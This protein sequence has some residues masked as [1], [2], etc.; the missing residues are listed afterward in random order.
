MAAGLSRLF[1]PIRL[2]HLTAK[3]RIVSTPH[4]TGYGV[5]GRLTER[6]IRYHEEKARG[7]CGVVMMFGSS[8]VHPSSAVDWGEVNNLDDSIVPDFRRMSEA[9]HRHDAIV[10]SQI[11]HRGRRGTSAYSGYPLWAPSDVRAETHR[12][13][14]H[15]MTREEIAEVVAAYAMAARRL[16]EGGFDGADVPL[17]GGHLPEQF[18]SPLSNRRDDEYGGSLENRLRFSVEIFRAI[19]ATVGRDF[20]LG[21]R[22]SGDHFIEGGLGVA[23]MQ[24]VAAYLDGLGL[25]DYAIVSGSVPETI[26]LQA[27]VTPSLYYPRGVYNHLAAAIREVVSL[28]VIVAGRVVTPQMAEEVLA[29]GWAD[30]V[31]MTRA[32]I[33]DPEMPQK[34]QEGRLDDIRICVGAN[35]GCIG[36][37]RQGKPISCVQ[38]PTI[39]REAELSAIVPAAASKRVVVVGGGPAGLEAARVAALRGHHVV[40]FEQEEHLGG[41]I[42]ALAQAPK[43]EEYAGIVTW[44]T[45]QVGKLGVDVRLGTTATIDAVRAERPDAIVVATGAAPRR[46]NL[47][48]ANGPNVVTAY[49]VLLGRSAVGDRCIIIDEEG[50]FEAPTTADF[51]A[52]CGKQVQIVCRFYNVG[53]DIDENV[54]A[55]VYG[56]LFKHGITLTPLTVAQEIRP[57]QVQTRHVYSG[58]LA[59]LEADTVVLAFGGQARDDL[60]YQLR[61]SAAQ[62]YLVGDAV[63]PRRIHDAILD[64]TRTARAI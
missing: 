27:A 19:R 42:I 24:A 5:E 61:G 39:G 52:A 46:P 1:S 29:N 16:K 54:R 32:I 40:L 45:G 38:N 64:G 58:E 35:E 49:D 62:V 15:V 12:E 17:Y 13:W 25:L 26:A 60:Y 7:G 55:D 44:L 31:G 22:L 20:I 21:T 18:L 28:P 30:L 33:A 34:A 51:L 9:V 4:G 10:I 47:P 48:G 2:G 50:Y 63:A 8:S 37:L 14:P 59:T 3:N 43:R 41:Q 36:R 6:Y 56:R 53:E 23:D 11:S 57:G